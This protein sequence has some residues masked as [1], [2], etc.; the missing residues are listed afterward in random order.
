MNTYR[1]TSRILLTLLLAATVS[2]APDVADIEGRWLSGAGDGW[3][4]IR[5]EDD[6]LNGFIAGSPNDILGD[7]PRMD[8][9]NPDAALRT[10]ELD[11]LKFLQGFRYVEKK[12]R[13]TDGTIYDPNSGKTYKGT[14]TLVDLNTLKLRGYIGVSLFG[15]NDIWTRIEP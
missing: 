15:R 6:T 3:I 12:N 8:V 14:I 5:I 7:P 10:R 11:G 13:W 4:D 1:R 2:A 9:E